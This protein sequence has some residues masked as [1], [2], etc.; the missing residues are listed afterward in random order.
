M[1]IIGTQSLETKR[2][3][4]RKIRLDDA[5]D[6]FNNWATNP[7]VTKYVT[8]DVHSSIEVTKTFIQSVV[9]G[10]DNLDN[11]HWAI[12]L[13]SLNQ[14]IGTISIVRMNKELEEVEIGY[15]LGEKWWNQG[16]ITEALKKVIEFLFNEVDVK[17]I[18]A[19][20]IK[21]NVAS[22]KVMI[23][24]GMRYVKE[25]TIN[26]RGKELKLVYYEIRK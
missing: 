19:S 15:C 10:Y 9:D 23:K 22:G 26:H 4:L 3:I 14:I 7:N 12:E 11:Y 1:K 25:V 17:V 16:I 2:L 24:N 20:Y 5:K 8:W 18:I 13:K 6:M 21:D